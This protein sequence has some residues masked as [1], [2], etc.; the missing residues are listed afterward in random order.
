VLE[1]SNEPLVSYVI[2]IRNMEHTVGKTIESIL[3]QEY[4]NKEIIVI[5]DGSDDHTEDVLK[6]YPIKS[7]NTEKIGISNA[8]NLGLKNSKGK[9]IAFTDADCELDPLWTKNMLKY[10]N[11]KNVGLVGGVTHFR[12]DGTYCSIY[13]N[14]EFS[15]RY[16][17]IKSKEVFHVGGPGFIARKSVLNEVGGFNPKWVYAEDVEM[18]FLV[19]EKGYKVLKQDN[20]ITY[21]I[22]ENSFKRLVKKGLCDSKAYVRVAISHKKSSLLNKFHNTWYFRY[23]LIILPI[24]YAILILTFIIYPTTI[25]LNH[26]VFKNYV[27][28]YLLKI[29]FWIILIIYLFLFIYGIIPSI[30]VY[31]KSKKLKHF[32]GSLLLHHIR[33]FAWGLGLLIGIKNIFF[34]KN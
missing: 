5:N 16:K 13:R 3:N 11:D 12:T 17:N 8:R 9:F 30:Q 15:K 23:D 18:S 34:K 29:F 1:I 25:L 20:A 31:L 2:G 32:F 10:F 33:G 27:L 7:I 6:R 22:P 4:P 14:L 21:H 19:I 24:M 28:D 26:I